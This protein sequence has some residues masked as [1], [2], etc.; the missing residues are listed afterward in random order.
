MQK[1]KFHKTNVIF[2]PSLKPNYISG[3]YGFFMSARE[4]LQGEQQAAMKMC[5]IG[6]KGVKE[7]IHTAVTFIGDYWNFLDI[8]ELPD[9]LDQPM[10][11]VFQEKQGEERKQDSIL[12][13]LEKNLTNQ[14]WLGGQLPCSGDRETFNTLKGK[15]IDVEKY[16]YTFAWFNLVSR[17]TDTVRESWTDQE[18]T[19]DPQT[20]LQTQEVQST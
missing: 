5:V 17:F 15:L 18:V 12:D 6:P 2:I 16:P 9:R 1:L 11:V 10:E 8:I 7:A 19:L 13:N 4:M 20:G 14:Q 3:F